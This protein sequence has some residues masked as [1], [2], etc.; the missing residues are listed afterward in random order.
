MKYVEL[1][2][3]EDKATSASVGKYRKS[4]VKKKLWI[5]VPGCYLKNRYF[6][7]PIYVSFQSF[8]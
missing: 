8:P 5:E 2:P 4:V 1:R 3:H 6:W 7:F